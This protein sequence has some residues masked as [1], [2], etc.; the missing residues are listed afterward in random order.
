MK[1]CHNLKMGVN[2][3]K[4]GK[5]KKLCYRLQYLQEKSIINALKQKFYTKSR[6][7]FL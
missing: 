1:F 4:N 3:V 7:S 5:L 2:P 6:Y